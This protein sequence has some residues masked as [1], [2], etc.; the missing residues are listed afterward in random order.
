VRTFGWLVMLALVAGA[1]GV[2][3]AHEGHDHEHDRPPAVAWPDALYLPTPFPDRICLS[4]TADAA[5]EIAV[6]WRTIPASGASRLEIAV[7]EGGPDFVGKAKQ[8]EGSS[9]LLATDLGQARY[10][11]ARA[12]GLEPATR[13]LYRV[14]DGEHWSEWCQTE[15]AAAAAAPFVF[16][17]F[18]DAQN[19]VRSHWSRVVRNAFR[20]APRAAFFLHA[21]DLINRAESDREWGEWFYASGFI[22]RTIPALATPGNHEMARGDNG[23]RLSHHWRPTF[24]FPE[25]GPPGLTETCYAID[26][27]GARIVSLNS[28]EQIAEQAEWLTEA[29]ADESPTWKIVTFHHPVFSS[30]KGR[31]NQ[32]LREAWQ[33]LFDRLG[34]DL[35]LQGHDHT[36]AR[37]PKLTFEPGSLEEVNVAVGRERQQSDSGTVYVVSVSGPKMYDLEPQPVMA[38]W[39]TRTQLYQVISVEPN[40]LSYRALNAI[41]DVHDAFRL[42]RSEDGSTTLVN[43]VERPETP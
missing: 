19:D 18:G 34:V 29:L 24:A 13:Y 8:I 3:L 40:R 17:Y 32:E 16:V 39:A 11:E 21:G 38:N 42:E 14:G 2:G 1:C 41:G 26:Y 6:T 25:Q 43:E 20:D 31:D 23:R 37:S 27:Q 10:H 30:A 4:I 12:T 5:H 9:S 7:A 15:T 33:P 22:H 35:V 36:Y 28:N